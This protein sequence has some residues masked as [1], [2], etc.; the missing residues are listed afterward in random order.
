MTSNKGGRLP[1][2]DRL[3][4]LAL[5]VMAMLWGSTFFVLHDMLER[6]DAADLLGVRFT[7]A[8][9]VFAAVVH[10]KLIINRTTLRQGAILGLIFGSAQLLQTYGLAYTSASIS[11]FLTGI[12]VV[13]TPILEALLFKARVRQRVWVAV[14]LATVGLAALTIAPGAGMVQFGIG[15]T[16]T[17][18]SALLYAMHIIYTGR[19]ATEQKAVTLAVFQTAGTA[20]LCLIGAIP[21]GIHFPQ[22]T[23]DWMALLYLALICGA[24]TAV[25]QTWA[26]SK[27]AATPSAVIMSSEPIWAATFA[28]LVG[29][30][31]FSMR[32]LVGGAAMVTA[33]VLSS[34]PDRS[35]TAMLRFEGK[36]A[37]RP[38]TDECHGHRPAESGSEPLGAY[39]SDPDPAH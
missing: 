4:P 38:P 33:M 21:G 31:A 13:L 36:T 34:L 8:A 2:A 20:V 15:E 29:Q 5:L 25:L 22:R 11:G 12:Y 32:T 7:I 16:L 1:V 6:V 26:Q 10:R 30:E 39:R 35:R 24:L 37:L 19:V 3:A 27:I 14:G 18:V 17:I 28:I 23:D 9:V